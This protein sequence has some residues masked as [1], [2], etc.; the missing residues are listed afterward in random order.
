[1]LKEKR[2]EKHKITYDYLDNFDLEKEPVMTLEESIKQHERI[3]ELFEE[4][5][6]D[7]DFQKRID[8]KLKSLGL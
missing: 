5:E 6:K 2:K 4:S 8:E 1:M 3:Q 7:E